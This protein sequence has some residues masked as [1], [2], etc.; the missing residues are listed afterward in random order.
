MKKQFLDLGKQPIANGFLDKADIENEFFFNLKVG[1]DDETNLVSLMNFVEPEKMFNDTYVYHSSM[2][3]TMREH[4]HQ[5]AEIFKKKF[6][7]S[8]VL[9]IGSNDGVFIKNFD[10]STTVAVEPCGN[11]AT[12]TNKQGYKTYSEFW[13]RELSEKINLENSKMDLIYSANCMCHIQDL[14]EA[15]SAVKHVLSPNGVF[16]FEDPS[17]ARMIYRGS[18]DQIYDEHAH[19]FSIL[20]LDKLLCQHS[21]EIFK[22]ENLE[23]HGGS[24]RVYVKHCDNI[25]LE[26]HSSVSKNILFEKRLGLDNFKTY[27][28]FASDVAESRQILVSLLKNL[29]S[30]GK[31]IV[32]YGATSKSTTVFNYCGIG[33]DLIDYIVDTTKDKQ[34][35]FSPGVRIPVISPEQG[36]DDT[37]D[38][39][40][41]GA[42]NFKKE[43]LNKEKS[44]LNSGGKFL[45]HVPTVSMLES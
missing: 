6:N 15:F 41:L 29:K 40:F 10:K 30:E 19:I 3:Q 13:S 38:V 24:N 18:Y 39:A 28:N 9:E 25:S 17:L 23:V 36:F 2:S 5:A 12:I 22:V 44:F 21:L 7:P 42:W 32:S 33:P 34:G 35:K 26:I 31:K 45:T 27:E 16:I 43:I 14:D 37:V 4:F 1:F 20:A 11:F 8:S